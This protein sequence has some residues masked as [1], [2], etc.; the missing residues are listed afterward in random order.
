MGATIIR[1]DKDS[2]ADSAGGENSSED[3][4]EINWMETKGW[5]DQTLTLNTIADKDKHPHIP[6]A[7]L[8][9]YHFDFRHMPFSKLKEMAKQGSLPNS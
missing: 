9:C 1:D 6:T 5:R 3:K 4:G 8:L 2:I 7:K